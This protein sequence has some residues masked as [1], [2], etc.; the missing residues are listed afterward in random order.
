[1]RVKTSVLSAR[2]TQEVATAVGDL[3]TAVATGWNVDH[4]PDGSHEFPWVDQTYVA[5]HFSGNNGMTW[6]VTG[7]T[8]WRYR[9]VGTTLDVVLDA[10]GT[11]GGLGLST[12]LT[13]QIPG[14]FTAAR[15]G[16]AG[17][18]AYLDA[19]TPGTGVA[20]VS[21]TKI[22]FFKNLNAPAWTAGTGK[23]AAVLRFE[24]Q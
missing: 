22:F 15:T 21:G 23:V 5:S 6:T 8:E 1:M 9:L 24:V 20:T 7:V 12:A 16:Q 13:A 2:T 11:V 14:G 3:A 4:N 10:S 17:T 19:G 18:F